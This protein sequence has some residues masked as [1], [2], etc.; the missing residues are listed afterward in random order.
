MKK[1]V[2]I[3]VGGTDIKY[4][5]IQEDGKILINR[6]VPTQVTAEGNRI[7][8]Q[9]QEIIRSIKFLKPV[10]FD[11]TRVVFAEHRNNAGMLG[12]FYNLVS[13][14]KADCDAQMKGKGK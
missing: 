14:M 5:L 7:L 6:K 12:A 10:I 4:G 8:D 3:D 1:Y 2:C 13:V 11:K 9:L